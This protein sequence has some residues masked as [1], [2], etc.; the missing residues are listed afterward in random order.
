MEQ[1]DRALEKG[2]S[3][4]KLINQ[5]LL[6]LKYLLKVCFIRT[7]LKTT[8]FIKLKSSLANSI[9]KARR[10]TNNMFKDAAKYG[11]TLLFL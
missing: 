6:S 7:P 8:H 5:V 9:L 3:I 10:L 2:H 4:A 1:S 11:R